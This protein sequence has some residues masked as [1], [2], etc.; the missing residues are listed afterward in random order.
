MTIFGVLAHSHRTAAALR[1]HKAHEFISSFPRDRKAWWIDP[2]GRV[3]LYDAKIVK[4]QSGAIAVLV[5]SDSLSNQKGTTA[6]VSA[7]RCP[8]FMSGLNALAQIN[9][10]FALAC[11][12][13]SRARLTLA[14]DHLGQR[15]LYVSH[16]E[17]LSL[18]CSALDP[19]LEDR[20]WPREM[21]F[22]SAT[23]YLARGLP[24]RNRTLAKGIQSIPAAHALCWESSA[25][26]ILQRYWSPLVF[27][28]TPKTRSELWQ[29]TKSALDQAISSRLVSR[30]SGLL[31]SGG[32]DSSYIAVTA[33]SKIPA[34]Q[35]TAYT[36]TYDP[37]Y[38]KNEDRFAA[39]VAGRIGIEHK[40]V[41]ISAKQASS[42]LEDVLK[43][44]IPC[45]AWAAIIH[46]R[47]LG[48]VRKQK[49]KILLS[50]LGA[51]ELFGGYDR[52]L[53][54]YFRQR[55]FARQWKSKKI[56]W[57]D[58]LLDRPVDA[59]YCLFP[60]M[61]SFFSSR[62]LQRWLSR[63][64]ALTD[65]NHEDREFYR[66]CRRLKPDAHIF[67]MMVAHECQHRIPD[68]LMS[69][70]EP[71][72]QRMG[73]WTSYPFLDFTLAS[74]AA[75]LGPSDRYWYE[76]G[77]WWAKKFFRQIAAEVLPDSIVMRRRATYEPPIVEWLTEPLFGPRALERFA[78]SSFW[79]LGL[80]RRSLRTDLIKRVRKL[81]N[82]YYTDRQWL[83]EFW[84]VLT[85][86]AWF[87][88]YIARVR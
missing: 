49:K 13:S 6:L 65:T 16:R 69:N 60:G 52:Y 61:A 33:R 82:S 14:R 18:F 40:L 37:R 7:L 59:A 30:A 53:D 12:N 77:Y 71:I 8:D 10:D 62:Q 2:Q 44:P 80:V 29:G 9:G 28:S 31:L 23:H 5:D 81:P 66:E 21:D 43:S 85:L 1:K 70:F 27:N 32:V 19:L 67:E 48:Q 20:D 50:G 22:E 42:I 25:L 54:Y 41:P 3:A 56:G 64:F 76:N 74:W 73:V 11:W 79:N 46:Q 83:E 87:D 47:L 24:L 39:E 75:L 57:F 35:L 45:S 72:A 34:K 36:I 38:N 78:S 15:Q 51:D 88:R 68:L 4:T 86:A 26:P 84:A 58:A 17:D 55:A 63:R